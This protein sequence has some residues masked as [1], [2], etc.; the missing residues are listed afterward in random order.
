[1][2]LREEVSVQDW[3]GVRYDTA[4]DPTVVAV[5]REVLGGDYGGSGY[6]TRAQAD[7]L[8]REL[9]LGPG[10]DLLDLGSGCGWP[11][12]HLAASTG[13]RVV[14]TDLTEQG[15]RQARARAGADGLSRLVDVAVSSARHLPF[16][17][18]SFDA[19]VHTDVLC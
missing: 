3:Y 13:A 10:A 18:E 14:L 19:I 5:E 12:V 8:A 2:A 9:R 11:G 15:I 17:P 6:T 1:M 16:R 7:R 4:T